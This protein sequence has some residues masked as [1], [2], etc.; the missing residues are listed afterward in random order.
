L[1][2]CFEEAGAAWKE[3]G[4]VE[5]RDYF[6]E[7]AI[8]Q[9]YGHFIHRPLGTY[10]NSVIAAGCTLQRIIEPQL[11]KTIAELHHAERY[12][13]VPGYIIIFATKS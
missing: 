11:E 7:R 6:R 12:W 5:V 3:K 9:T 8:K 4:Y 1:H 13:S 10:L 2:P